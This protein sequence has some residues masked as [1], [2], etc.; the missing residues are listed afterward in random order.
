MNRAI[1]FANRPSA[2]NWHGLFGE[3]VV[4]EAPAPRVS[5]AEFVRGIAQRFQAAL[6]AIAHSRQTAAQV[7]GWQRQAK[8]MEAV[9]DY[10]V[11]GRHARMVIRW[12]VPLEGVEFPSISPGSDWLFVTQNRESLLATVLLWL[13]DRGQPFT[14][15]RECG[16]GRDCDRERFHFRKRKYCCSEHRLQ[17]NRSDSRQRSIDHYERKKAIRRLSKQFPSSAEKLV[18]AVR[19]RG[20]HASAEELVRR[21]SEYH[22]KHK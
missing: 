18:K 11:E 6:S 7:E 12:R 16:R 14:G 10:F 22:E 17:E 19:K 15:L 9:P 2:G 8:G 3:K 13:V 21:A 1:R 4:Y 5:N 20:E